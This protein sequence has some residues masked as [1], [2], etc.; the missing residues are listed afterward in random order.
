MKRRRR[1]FTLGTVLMLLITLAVGIGCYLVLPRLTGG[2]AIQVDA[3]QVVSALAADLSLPELTLSDIPIF[4]TRASTVPPAA[5]SAPPLEMALEQAATPQPPPPALSTATA[6]P[7]A[8]SFTLTAG[9]SVTLT[10]PLRKSVYHSESETYDFTE[11]FGYIA[12]ETR[13]DLCLVTLENTLD[14]GGKLSDVNTAA[15]AADALR[16]VGVDVVASG[17]PKALDAGLPALRATLSALKQEGFSVVGAYA[18]QE[19]AQQPLLLNLHGVQTAVLHYTQFLSDKGEATAEKEE[20]AYA[21]PRLDIE[22]VR[23]AIAAARARGA[24]VVILSLNWGNVG[25]SAPTKAQQALAQELA[26]AG[27]DIILGAHSQMIQP[28]QLLT[29]NRAGGVQTQALVAYSLGALITQERGDKYIAGM[30]LHLDL[31]YHTDTR[32]LSFDQIQ[33]TPTYIWRYK[34]DGRYQYRVVPSDLV[35][36]DGMDQKQQEVMGRALKTTQT[37][38]EGSPVTLRTPGE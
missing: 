17:F 15:G 7:Q 22:T 9:G 29:A 38:L 37:A 4:Q 11:L 10:T 33:Y 27:A 26:D 30:L 34:E 8:L 35:A 24:Q 20:A 6:A 3:Q 12:D 16:A 32:S 5:P 1:G 18:S 25:K 36:P 21:V 14:T 2:Q 19:D 13:S 31:T 28:I 23:Q